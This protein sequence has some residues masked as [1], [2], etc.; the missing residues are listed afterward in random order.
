V[1]DTLC[2]ANG[3]DFRD[4]TD[5]TVWFYGHDQGNGAVSGPR[6]GLTRTE[7]NAPGPLGSYGRPIPRTPL[8][9][10]DARGA[11]GAKERDFD[12]IKR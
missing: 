3:G 1:S 5:G 11:R 9:V 8:R 10:E 6:S 12:F 4:T 7:W 2:A